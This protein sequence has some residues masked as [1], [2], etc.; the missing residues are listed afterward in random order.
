MPVCVVVWDVNM[1]SDKYRFALYV[2]VFYVAI[3][4]VLTIMYMQWIYV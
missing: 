2:C 4:C 3:I 1:K